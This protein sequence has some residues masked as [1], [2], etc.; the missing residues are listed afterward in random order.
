MGQSSRPSICAVAPRRYALTQ[1][2]GPPL[3]AV[4]KLRRQDFEDV[5]P[6][7]LFCRQIY[8]IS[9]CSIY[10]PKTFGNPSSPLLVYA[11]YEKHFMAF[12]LIKTRENDKRG[13]YKATFRI[14]DPQPIRLQETVLLIFG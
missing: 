2:R 1:P 8:Y 3:G 4:L 6:P 7:S 13:R 10:L 11:V 5:L 14:V 12:C 9:L